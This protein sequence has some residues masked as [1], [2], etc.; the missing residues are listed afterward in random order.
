[1]KYKKTQARG[2]L[3]IFALIKFEV[4]EGHQNLIHSQFVKQIPNNKLQITNKYQIPTLK[5]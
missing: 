1:M 4:R 2:Q 5:Q 3:T